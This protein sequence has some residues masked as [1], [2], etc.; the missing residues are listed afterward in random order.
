V[1]EEREMGGCSSAARFLLVSYLCHVMQTLWH[2]ALMK[3]QV[4]RDAASLGYILSNRDGDRL[5]PIR[6]LALGLIAASR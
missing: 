2:V 3:L 1:E 6:T 4:D 5:Y